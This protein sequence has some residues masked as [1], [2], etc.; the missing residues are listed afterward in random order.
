MTG[1]TDGLVGR[2]GPSIE[3][4]SVPRRGRVEVFAQDGECLLYHP[5]RDE[6][7]ALNRTATDVWTLCDGALSVDAIARSLASRY[8][9]DD[10]ALADDVGAAL[11]DLLARG[12]I[13]IRTGEPADSR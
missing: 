12:L 7:T 5:D 10:D 13:E 3:R 8:G 6:A 4:T 11:R 9:V 1:E 2:S